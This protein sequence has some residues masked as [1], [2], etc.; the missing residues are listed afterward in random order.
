ME[1][2]KILK[3]DVLDIIFDGKNKSYGAYDL[4]RSY[5]KRVKKSL[6][7]T[8]AVALLFFFSSVFANF[9]GKGKKDSIDVIDTQMAKLQET[10][11]PVI[12]PPPKVTPPPQVDMNKVRFVAPVIVKDEDV[13]P[14]DKI[15]D[16]QD[17][18]AISTETKLSDNTTQI[19]QAPVDEP[20]GTGAVQ[21]LDKPDDQDKIFLKV[22]K[23][24]AFDGDWNSFLKRNLDPETPANNDAPEGTYT[25]IVKFVVSK[26]GSLSN[27]ECEAD[28]GYGICKEAIR[29][30]KKTKNWIPAVQNGNN[31][32]AYRRQPITFVVGQQ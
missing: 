30:I 1:T 21:V 7:I 11:P 28:P 22:E 23:E 17:N 5:N 32:N 8:G 19:I 20:K 2:N 18:Q 9:I 13:Q 6:A 27:I 29:V 15:E 26:D 25:V 14:E 10:P 16:V 24:A 12:P 4:R 3:A 31:V